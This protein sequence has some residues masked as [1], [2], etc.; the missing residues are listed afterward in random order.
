M[1]M[2]W[3]DTLTK[4]ELVDR[5][6]QH[7]LFSVGTFNQLRQRLVHFVRENEALFPECLQE[8]SRDD[9]IG[10]LHGGDEL[11]GGLRRPTGKSSD[12]RVTQG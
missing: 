5:M 8:P 12:T 9:K 11:G 2:N 6:E 1:G 7:H 4:E 3:V 10:T